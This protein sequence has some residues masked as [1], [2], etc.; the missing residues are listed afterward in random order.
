VQGVFYRQ[1]TRDKAKDL[2]L[3]GWV[4]NVRN[5]DVEIVCEGDE[6]DVAA[7]IVWCKAGPP[8]AL[9]RDVKTEWRVYTGE[10]K[11]FQIKY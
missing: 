1:S 11:S 10:F 4:R 8:A 3:T 2:L 6:E 5:G 7:L 9:V